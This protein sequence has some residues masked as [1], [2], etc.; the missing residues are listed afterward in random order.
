SAV[1]SSA[2]GNGISGSNSSTMPSVAYLSGTLY[3]AW[4]AI[5]GGAGNI[6]AATNNRS[7]GAAGA[8]G[9]PLRAGAEPSSRGAATH[10]QL[11]A[12]GG[13]LD[14][15]WFEDRLTSSPNQAVAIYATRLSGGSF[16]RQLPGDASFD[17]ILHRSTSLANTASLALALDSAGHPYVA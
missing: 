3:V 7:A 10:P 16:I 12:N 8:G 1:N 15:V 11:S 14:L 5:T 4:A 2:S 6:V 9:T 13:A 17:G